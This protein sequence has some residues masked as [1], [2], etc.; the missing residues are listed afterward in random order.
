MV[1]LFELFYLANHIMSNYLFDV[2][3]FHGKTMFIFVWN[4]SPECVEVVNCHLIVCMVSI[5]IQLDKFLTEVII[6]FIGFG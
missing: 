2:V 3:R 4:T 6:G 1:C 5:S